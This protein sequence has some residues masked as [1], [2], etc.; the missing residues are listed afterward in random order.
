MRADP[1]VEIP[2]VVKT[3]SGSRPLERPE[4]LLGNMFGLM[5]V[6]FV[7]AGLTERNWGVVLFGLLAFVAV[8]VPGQLIKRL[9][10]G[11][12]DA[13]GDIVGRISL[14]YAIASAFV[15]LTD[16]SR[17]GTLLAAAALSPPALLASRAGAH[18]LGV[19]IRRRRGIKERVLIVGAGVV[20]GR[21]IAS[22]ASRPEYGFEVAGVVDDDPLLGAA[23]LGTPILG[24]LDDIRELV[25]IHDIDGVIVTFSRADGRRMANALRTA[26]NCGVTT[27]VVPRLFELGQEGRRSREHLWG[28]PLLRLYR[29]ARQR[30]E[31]IVK[32]AL[33][34]LMAGALLL[35]FSPLLAAIALLVFVDLGRPIFHR[36]ERVGVDGRPFTLLKFRSMHSEEAYVEGTEWSASSDRVT[37]VGRILR[38]TSLDEV[39]QLINVLRGDMSVVGPRPER[40]HFA[41]LF[42]EE[43]P[44]YSARHRL[45]GG[46]TGWAQIHGLCGDTSIEDRTVF[47]NYYIE[48]WSLAQDL[49]ILLR[50]MRTV[51]KKFKAEAIQLKAGART[52]LAEEK[53]V[54][55][56]TTEQEAESRIREAAQVAAEPEAARL[57]AEADELAVQAEVLEVRAVEFETEAEEL[58]AAA[59]ELKQ[60]LQREASELAREARA[61]EPA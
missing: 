20:A 17:M 36:Q 50:T 1:A 33:D 41:T 48:H 31:W 2:A 19:A 53:R 11:A 7:T 3:L 29:P 9:G 6:L 8:S 13:V 32:R 43:F 49:K 26:M 55:A 46:M 5:L 45:P 12:L 14:A 57:R 51:M 37:R 34:F 59:D 39:P 47:D 58:Q 23:Q 24:R 21:V 40:P 56:K 4:I 22:L 60:E 18:A 42:E 44:G 27:W 61:E 35:L 10:S 52:A 16:P 28:L 54:E 25:R 30:P 38:T 15:Y